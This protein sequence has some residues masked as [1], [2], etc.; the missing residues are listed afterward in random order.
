MLKGQ[1]H[2]LTL[3]VAHQCSAVI[4][5]LTAF[6]VLAFGVPG[7]RQTGACLTITE[8]SALCVDTVTMA[9]AWLA[10]VPRLHWVAIV[11]RCTANSHKEYSILA[12]LTDVAMH[13][14]QNQNVPNQ[15]DIWIYFGKNS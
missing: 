4:S 6:T 7:T 13:Q 12:F 11:T 15:M 14:L 10:R 1:K 8:I 9:L 2:W 5:T 3:A